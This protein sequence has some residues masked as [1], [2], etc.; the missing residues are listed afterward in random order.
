M[1]ISCPDCAVRSVC[2]KCALRITWTPFRREEWLSRLLRAVRYS[3]RSAC[4]NEYRVSRRE[5]RILVRVAATFYRLGFLQIGL[6]WPIAK[7]EG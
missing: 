5:Q 1:G 7:A 6:L 3:V 4:E 2:G